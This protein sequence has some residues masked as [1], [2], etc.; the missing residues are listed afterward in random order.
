MRDYNIGIVLDALDA[1]GVADSTVVVVTGD[2][3]WELGEHA[4]WCK[5]HKDHCSCCFLK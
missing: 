3:G 1:Q 5:V 2:H 4:E